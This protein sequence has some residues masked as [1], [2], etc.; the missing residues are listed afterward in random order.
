MCVCVCV[1]VCV[2]TL[3]YMYVCVCTYLYTCRMAATEIGN[4][5]DKCVA[6][7]RKEQLLVVKKGAG[8]NHPERSGSHRNTHNPDVHMFFSPD[9]DAA[10][11]KQ[12]APRRRVHANVAHRVRLR[13]CVH[14]RRRI[15]TA[16]MRRAHSLACTITSTLNA[17][18]A[19]PRTRARALHLSHSLADV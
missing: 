9:E 5:P 18:R 4:D 8:S 7:N 12:K 6:W 3:I 2:C 11:V 13:V 19:R 14:A 1:C 16:Q 15:R 17:S 10:T